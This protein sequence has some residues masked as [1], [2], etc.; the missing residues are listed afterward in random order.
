MGASPESTGHPES[1]WD[2]EQLCVTFRGTSFLGCTH[3]SRGRDESLRTQME[4][5]GQ[6]VKALYFLFRDA[7]PMSP[8]KLPTSASESNK[9]KEKC[10]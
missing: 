2:S 6:K 5:E 4:R 1:P 3:A 9:G 7:A 10:L 8:T